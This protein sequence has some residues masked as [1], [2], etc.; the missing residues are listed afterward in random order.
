MSS[1]SLAVMPLPKYETWFMEAKLI[2]DYHYLL[3][4]DDYSDLDE[5]MEYYINH[6]EKALEIIRNAHIYIEQFR[7]RRREDLILLLVLEKYFYRT[8]QAELRNDLKLLLTHGK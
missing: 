3:I 2:P 5:R 6:P 7:M 8:N 4:K 1:Q